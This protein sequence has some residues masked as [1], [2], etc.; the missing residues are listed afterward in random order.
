MNLFGIGPLELFF[1][2]IIAILVFGP[3]KL[4]KLGTTIGKVVRDFRKVSSVMK[5]EI[6]SQIMEEEDDSEAE[7]KHTPPAHKES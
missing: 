2:F 1:I 6:T 4:P 3:D 7:D 5:Q